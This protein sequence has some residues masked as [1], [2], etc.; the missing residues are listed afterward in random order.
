[1]FFSLQVWL[2]AVV[3]VLPAVVNGFSWTR[4]AR[5]Y[6]SH[7]IPGPR[8]ATYL[9]GL[10]ISSTST[11]VYSSYF[12]WRVCALYQVKFPLAAM[13]ILDRSIY[14]AALLSLVAILCFFLGRGPYRLALTVGALWV[15]LLMWI[16]GGVLHWA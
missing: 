11:F 13:I 3:I 12:A 10:V 6:R 5:F 2:A 1:M 14:P 15:A 8:R 7:Q 9:L 16:H 4:M